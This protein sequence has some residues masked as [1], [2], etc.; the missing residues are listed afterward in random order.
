MEKR[1]T[2]NIWQALSL[3]ACAGVLWFQWHGFG[4]LEE[5]SEFTGGS[6]TG[7]L[8]FMADLSLIFFV[9]A[10]LV[11]T[12]SSRVGTVIGLIACILCLPLYLYVLMPGPFRYVFK[13]EYSV[14]IQRQIVW[15]TWA[16]LGILSLLAAVVAGMRNFSTLRD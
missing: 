14:P 6:V 12:F 9:V 2:R 5:A 15:N 10:A 7:T 8:F 3:L 1:N 16:A 4:G 11:A 13:G